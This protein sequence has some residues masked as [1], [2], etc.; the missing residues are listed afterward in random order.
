MGVLGGTFN[1]IHLGHLYIAQHAQRLFG[2]TEVRFVV[3]TVPPHK[4]LK[5]LI[6]LIH[7]YAMVSLAVAG[8]R[9]FAPSLVELEPPASPFS[10]HTMGKMARRHAGGGKK[11]CF[12]AGSDS[13]MEVSNWRD[14]DELLST[15]DFVFFMRPGAALPDVKAV[16]SSEVS[17]R[18]LD[19]RG[20][21]SRK[22]RDRLATLKQRRD[23][24][25]FVLDLAAPD[26]SASR[27]RDLASSGRRIRH[28][29]P[30]AVNEYI[31]KLHLYGE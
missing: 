24:R 13:L 29:V 14:S 16:L 30:A 31:Q 18:V 21:G 5:N 17:S 15:Y 4:D 7:R 26:I 3:A 20:L 22:L 1:P 6:P 11:L 2:L 8:H 9:T 10:I 28:L 23:S 19:L 25:I 12:I 27:I